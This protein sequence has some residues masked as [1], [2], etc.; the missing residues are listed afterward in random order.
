MEGGVS[1]ILFTKGV[2]LWGIEQ[3]EWACKWERR[4]LNSNVLL[5]GQLTVTTFCLL[6]PTVR[7]GQHLFLSSTPCSQAYRAASTEHI[8]GPDPYL[9]R[10]SETGI[11]KSA[12][13]K[14]IVR[15]NTVPSKG[16]L[17][18]VSH[19]LRC[20]RSWWFLKHQSHYFMFTPLHD[21]GVVAI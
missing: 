11:L 14:K 21:L 7:E 8:A 20:V 1:C 10:S 13:S 5:S 15:S 17:W 6:T 3:F 18:E 16:A 19:S 2:I 4:D 9:K 12:L